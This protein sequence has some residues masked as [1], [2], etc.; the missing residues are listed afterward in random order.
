METD[1][2]L[3]DRESTGN[4][5]GIGTAR[6]HDKCEAE[7]PPWLWVSGPLV[8]GVVHIFDSTVVFLADT[9]LRSDS[10]L[11]LGDAGVNLVET[12]RGVHLHESVEVRISTIENINAMGGDPTVDG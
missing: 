10:V 3:R 7:E 6:M 4:L 11:I 5:G 8:L 12:Y 9:Q 1:L 2:V